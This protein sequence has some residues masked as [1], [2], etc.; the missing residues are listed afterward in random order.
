MTDVLHRLPRLLADIAR[1]APAP[2]VDPDLPGNVERVSGQ[3]ARC[4]RLTW[5]ESRRVDELSL[6]LKS[7]SPVV[8]LWWAI[9]PA[10]TP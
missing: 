2:G 6:D 1:H 3:Y 7:S 8:L 9:Y 10:R 4:M 5:R